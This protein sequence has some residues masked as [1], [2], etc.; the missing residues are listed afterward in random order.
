MVKEHRVP[1]LW[2]RCGDHATTEAISVMT[3]SSKAHPINGDLR[4]R[5]QQ[6]Q[7]S[8]RPD[9]RLNTHLEHRTAQA[10]DGKKFAQA[11]DGSG[12]RRHACAK[13]GRLPSRSESSNAS[14]RATRARAKKRCPDRLKPNGPGRQ[15]GSKY[16]QADSWAH[17]GGATTLQRGLYLSWQVAA[18]R[19]RVPSHIGYYFYLLKI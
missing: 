7:E 12:R 17:L 5:R 8:L 14:T 18:K 10:G 9:S 6:H 16:P 3:G 13:Y 1:M 15:S 2:N 4:Q 19:E 11:P